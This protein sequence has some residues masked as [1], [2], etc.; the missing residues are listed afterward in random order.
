MNRRI[1]LTQVFGIPLI[2]VFFFC[3]KEHAILI[4]NH[5]AIPVYL[6]YKTGKIADVQVN[7]HEKYP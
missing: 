1:E 5:R 6:I 2:P 4:D 7:R 3:S